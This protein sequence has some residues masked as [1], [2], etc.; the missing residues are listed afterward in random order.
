MVCEILTD[1]ILTKYTTHQEKVKSTMGKFLQNTMTTLLPAQEEI[2]T[3]NVHFV[4][5]DLEC[6]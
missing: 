3:P 1:E 5:D 2:V 4:P 6:V